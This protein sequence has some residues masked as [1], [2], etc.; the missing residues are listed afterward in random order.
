MSVLK[1]IRNMV[2]TLNSADERMYKIQQAL[3]RIEERQLSAK[4]PGCFNDYEFQVYS[5]WGEDGLI[6]YLVR[7][8]PLERRIFVEFG[9]EKYAESNTRFLLINDNWAGLLIDGSKQNIDYIR[10]D[11]IYWKYNLKAE[12][13]FID[14]D[15]INSLISGNGISDDIGLLSID[16]DGNDY[17]VWDAIQ[18]ISPRIVICEYNSLWGSELSVSIPYDPAFSRTLAHYS[19]LYF[20]ASIAALS[21]LANSKGYS[22]VGSNRA[23]NNAFYVRNDVITDIA[24]VSPRNAWVESKFRESRN[25]AGQLTYLSFPERLALVSDMPLVNLDDGKQYSVGE[26]FGLAC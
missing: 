15:N 26:L 23:G 19:N 3:G 17:W 10:N 21:K 7:D 20:G 13:S 4:L 6:Q 22:L 11:T 14:R 18:V 5:Q 8:T 24:I 12:C 2:R 25:K 9:V 16:I 1:K